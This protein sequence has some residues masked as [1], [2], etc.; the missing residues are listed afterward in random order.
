MGLT[1]HYSPPPLLSSEYASLAYLR[2][3][4][5]VQDGVDGAQEHGEGLV[6]EGE[7]H[8]IIE[9]LQPYFHTFSGENGWYLYWYRLS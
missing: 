9:Y 7:D 4:V 3:G 1:V 6:V 2:I 5:P 8:C